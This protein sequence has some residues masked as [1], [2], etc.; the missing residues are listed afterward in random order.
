M[1][2]GSTAE[3][4][5]GAILADRKLRITAGFRVFSVETGTDPLYAYEPD[6]LY[7]F[8]APVLSGSGTRWFATIRLKLLKNV[9]M[10]LKLSQTAYS[11]LSHVS[12]GNSGGLSGKF[13][14]GWRV[15]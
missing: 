2:K 1:T 7:G 10:E 9:D 12:Q 3:C 6:V 5:L 4:S 14:V 15:E 11:D 13:Q 8:S